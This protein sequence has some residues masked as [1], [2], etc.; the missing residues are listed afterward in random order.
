MFANDPA[1]VIDAAGATLSGLRTRLKK[2]LERVTLL[3]AKV[4]KGLVVVDETTMPS[5]KTM[6]VAASLR[7]GPRV[8]FVFVALNSGAAVV[9]L[10]PG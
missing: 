10:V 5:W 6:N 8:K 4:T 2:L 3:P 1:S 7:L 9:K